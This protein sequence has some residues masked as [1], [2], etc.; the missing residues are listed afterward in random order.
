MARPPKP[1]P[2]PKPQARKAVSQTFRV[3]KAAKKRER[4]RK[5]GRAFL[6]T[7]KHKP[8]KLPG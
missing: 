3:E 7:L 5:E 8:I 1:Q 2:P 6:A 4:I